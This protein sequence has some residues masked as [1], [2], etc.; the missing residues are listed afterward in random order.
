MTPSAS[1]RDQAQSARPFLL[2]WAV[3]SLLVLAG[4]KFLLFPS[5]LAE[6]MD[7]RQLYAAGYQVRT[8]PAHLYDYEQQ[9]AVQDRLVSQAAGL[10]PFIRPAYEALLFLP[11]SY[12]PYRAAYLCFLSVNLLCLLLSFFVC[13]PELSH[14]GRFAQPRAGLQIFLFYPVLV[15]IVQ[16]QDSV[17]MLLGLCLAYRC[18]K[19]GPGLA[20]GMLLGLVMFK[21]QI[22]IPLA[23]F[24][25]LRY[26]SFALFTGLAAGVAGT[27]LLSIGVSGYSFLPSFGRALKLTAAAT[28]APDGQPVLG[29][30]PGAMPNLKGLISGIT[31]NRL[32]ASVTF[33]LTLVL[34][35]A[36]ALVVLRR[37]R[38]ARP[39]L[40]VSFSAALTAALLLSYYLHLQ[41][42]ALLLLPLGFMAGRERQNFTVASRLLYIAPPFV[43]MLGHDLIFLLSVPLLFLL[44]A[45]GPADS[46][47]SL[48]ARA[49]ASA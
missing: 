9:K 37:L 48:R 21:P 3:F 31:L 24:L 23:A 46:G 40:E 19:S 10:L 5:G 12:L 14:A 16:G 47:P 2:V 38:A 35:V 20:A 18:L 17:L 39:P 4:A 30:A 34:S 42:L 33:L 7:F 36:I 22:A 26:P 27:V 45:T 13:R 11:L 49:T 41:D 1:S 43:V 15:A 6:R 32:P 28:L 44:A 29:V 25:L 8:D